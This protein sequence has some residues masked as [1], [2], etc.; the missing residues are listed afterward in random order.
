MTTII[1]FWIRNLF[2]GMA[3][4]A[5][6]T[7][8]EDVEVNKNTVQETGPQAA[9]KP[10][11]IFDTDISADCDDAG[12]MA[13]LHALADNGELEILAMMVSM[14]V[15]HGAPAL[16]AI[17]TFYKRPGIPIGTL[18]NSQDGANTGGLTT[19]NKDLAT[20]FS[21]DLRHASNAPNSVLLYR[22]LLSREKSKNVTILT[23]GPLTNLYH[24]MLSKPDSISP[25]NGVDLIKEK[26]VRLITAGGRLPEGSSYNFWISP[27]KAEHVINNWPTEHWF[28]PNQL[29]DSVLT[30]KEL[31]AKTT[32]ENPVRLAYTLYRE[33]HPEDAFRP[34]W[35]QMGVLIAARGTAGLFKKNTAGNVAATKEKIKWH[36]SPDKP[37]VWFSNDSSPE[38]RRKII[39]AL[40]IK[41]P[42]IR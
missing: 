27:E 2:C 26:V 10:K 42:G 8:D 17:N 34:S 37:H 14:P 13:V 3:L 23:V 19:Y 18:K 38:Q 1:L 24:L 41:P 32:P 20:R 16:D 28:V 11:I 12:A 35:D 5:C 36:P 29:G 31:I 21:N 39:E 25:L 15:E 6:M 30:G 9:S 33:I 7:Q 40:M 22:Q 4:A